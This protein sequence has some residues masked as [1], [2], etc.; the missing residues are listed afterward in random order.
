MLKRFYSLALMC[1]VLATAYAQST[2]NIIANPADG[3]T[4]EALSSVTL[5]FEGAASVDNG[6]KAGSIT[7][8]SDQG[9]NAG[10]T[11]AYGDAD[12]QMVVNFAEVTAAGT[13]TLTFPENAFTADV[14]IPAFTLTYKIGQEVAEGLLISPAGGTVTWLSDITVKAAAAP[15]KGVS[16]KWGAEVTPTLTGP[17][18]AQIVYD[19]NSVYDSNAGFS[20]YHIVPRLLI[21]TPGDYTLTIPDDYF[22]Y[23]DES[24]TSIS[25]PGTTVTYHVTAGQ[26]AVF[27]SSPSKDVPVSTFQTLTITFPNA[28]TVAA[29]MPLSIVLY[30]NAETWKGSASLSYNWNY[31]GNTMTYSAYSPI[32]DAGHYTMTFPEGCLLLDGEPSAPF[33]V[34]FDI[35]ENDPLN[36][37]VTPAQDASVEGLLNSAVITFPD[38]TDVTYNSG[39]ITLYR[40]TENGDVTIA[41]AYGTNTTVKQDDGKTFKVSFPGIATESGTYKISIPKNLF[42]TG[43]QF[44]AET[45][46]TFTYTAPEAVQPVVTPADG[47]ELDRVQKFTVSFPNETD[48]TV[49]TALTSTS[50]SLYKGVPYV[51]EYGYLVKNSI[52]SV[53]LNAIQQVDDHTF[54]FTFSNPGIEAG[55]YALEIPAGV[56]L[57]GNRTF[58]APVAYNVYT[59]TGNGLD[60]IVATPAQPVRSLKNITLTFVNET[61]VVFQTSYAS[62]TLYMVNPDASYNTYKEGVYNYESTWGGFVSLDEN[63]PNKLNIELMN[64]YTE[65]GEYYLDLTSYFLFMSDGVTPNTINKVYFTV[66]PTT[67]AIQDVQKAA[68]SDHRIYTIGGVEV[69]NASRP[70]LYIKDGKKI[71][72]K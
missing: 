35:V 26:Q 41:S 16:A 2:V 28:T 59:A 31:E 30:Q 68:A 21:T 24:Y 14:N 36:M 25:L 27:T 22:S 45:N 51:N 62:A 19:G 8:T 33:M 5:T 4:V 66:D 61:S 65:A 71:V 64:E 9:Y 1:L 6:S 69:K 43:E 67:T 52:S 50:I 60:K 20:T 57:M 54:S 17:D 32:I 23:Q 48:V 29:N 18:G 10:C 34:E 13:Y 70:G 47:V 44:N 72:R 39:S 3:S 58:N 49:N 42:T 12:N 37:V 7:I 15:N 55:E 38:E 46:V 11:L 63:Q 53:A 40:V 56:F